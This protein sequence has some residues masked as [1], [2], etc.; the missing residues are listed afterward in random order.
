MTQKSR[1]I[2]HSSVVYQNNLLERLKYYKWTCC[3]IKDFMNLD[4]SVFQT[5]NFYISYLRTCV[6]RLSLQ[7][8]YT[9]RTLRRNNYRRFDRHWTNTGVQLSYKVF[10]YSFYL[11]CTTVT[12]DQMFDMR[13]LLILSL[14]L[15]R[16]DLKYIPEGQFCQSNPLDL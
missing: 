16:G 12:T 4:V 6:S 14:C 7:S 9:R 11:L 5:Y 3:Q 2:A 15:L 13:F 1:K 10:V 8:W